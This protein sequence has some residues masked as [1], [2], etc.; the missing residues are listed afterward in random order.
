M[1]VLR[2]CLYMWDICYLTHKSAWST[3]DHKWRNSNTGWLVCSKS[4]FY[5]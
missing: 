1:N 4:D 5:M 3:C 2:N